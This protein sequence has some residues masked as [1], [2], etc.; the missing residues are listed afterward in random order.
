M[1]W[2]LDLSTLSTTASGTADPHWWNIG[3]Y[4]NSGLPPVK[5]YGGPSPWST[6]DNNWTALANNWVQP[7]QSNSAD[8]NAP[9]GIY[10]YTIW[11]YLP[12][13]AY[14]GV[15]LSG[16]FA[17][18]NEGSIYLNGHWLAD[19][20]APGSA[21]YC[22]AS[23][24]TGTQIIPPPLADFNTGFGATGLNAL[25]VVVRNFPSSLTGLSE[26]GV[27]V[28]AQVG[29]TC[30]GMCIPPPSGR[31]KICK[32]AGA[33]VAVGTAFTFTAGSS[34]FTVPAGPGP[35]GTCV[36]GP[37]VPA[38]S[39]VTVQE[40]IPTGDVV[41]SIT[42]SGPVIPNLPQG[43]A[44]VTVNG[45]VTE[46]TYTD[47]GVGYLK[48]CKVAGPGVGTG[49]YVNFKVSWGTHFT[50][51][52]VPTG[53]APGGNCQLGPSLPVG[54]NVMVQELLPSGDAVSNIAVA[55]AAPG[56]IVVAPNLGAGTVTVGLGTGVTE[57]TYT[58]QGLTGYLE[59]CKQ[60][61]TPPPRQLFPRGVLPADVT[62]TVSPSNS[63]PIVVPSGGCS[64]AIQ[65]PAGQVTIQEPLSSAYVMMSCATI[66]ASAQGGC[67]PANGISTVTIAQGG[68]STQTVATIVN[69]GLLPPPPCCYY[70]TNESAMGNSSSNPVTSVPPPIS[71][72]TLPSG[73]QLFSTEQQAA[74][75]CPADIVVWANTRTRIYHARGE[76]YYANTAK[77]AFVC[78]KEAVLQGYHSP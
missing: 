25:T 50:K 66:P 71:P 59:I 44:L 68:I 74:L 36:L 78:R 32:V 34:T 30:N 33:G 12:C 6:S 48:I 27:A 70:Q 61:Y 14:T 76:Q 42:A 67:D 20:L 49:Q 69:K 58:D 41:S 29:G 39:T 7:T 57:V 55:A 56:T 28:T 15:N 11:F 18:D 16:F 46:V 19:C 51:V 24:V 9:A 23:P 13:T 8:G 54:T 21:G 47:T 75:H 40:T 64:P 2:G 4:T 37:S 43:Q 73:L 72:A 60:G 35:E 31:L 5:S 3:P 53:P 1:S 52:L 77:G 45:P 62:F 65:V 10:T 17:A 38:G 63:G 22:F 26:T